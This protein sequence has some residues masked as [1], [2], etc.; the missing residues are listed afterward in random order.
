METP[1]ST[2]DR[3]HL[4]AKTER[5]ALIPL[6]HYLTYQTA[7]RETLHQKWQQIRSLR[8][9]NQSKEYAPSFRCLFRLIYTIIQCHL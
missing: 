1:F 7:D 8:I 6:R 3:S 5:A 4:Q 2:S 9:L